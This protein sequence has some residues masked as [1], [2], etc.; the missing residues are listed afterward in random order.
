MNRIILVGHC[1]PDASYLVLAARKAVADAQV[2]R[3]NSRTELETLLAESNG[4]PS[5]LLVNR[6]LDGEFG[7]A[8][9]I[10]L[11]ARLRGRTGARAMLI[12]NYADAQA[13][14][15][16]AGAMPGFGKRDIGSP[17]VLEL[18]RAALSTDAAQVR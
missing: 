1:G 5:L 12:S 9:G 8:D 16:A 18:I 17:R 10:E 13:L 15:E 3:A 4:T 11:I 2:V 6:V 7:D 14:A